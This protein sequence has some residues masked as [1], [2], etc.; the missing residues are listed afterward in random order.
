MTPRL[1]TTPAAATS[2]EAGRP[3]DSSRGTGRVVVPVAPP[4]F[5]TPRLAAH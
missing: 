3:I 2:G 4:V 5:W 1:L